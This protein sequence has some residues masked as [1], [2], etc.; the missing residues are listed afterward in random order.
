MIADYI[1]FSLCIMHCFLMLNAI[2][3]KFTPH[4]YIVEP[5]HLV[6]DK[7]II[8]Q[9]CSV[10]MAGYCRV[11]FFFAFLWTKTKSRSIKT[12]KRMRP[13]SSHLNG[14]SLINIGGFII[15]ARLH[16]RILLLQEQSGQSQAGKRPIA[17]PVL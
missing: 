6:T 5:A 12:Q 17:N 15:I 14:T 13:I 3:T 9:A 10:K 2:F 7:G 11:L 4:G 16:Q 8:D 1:T